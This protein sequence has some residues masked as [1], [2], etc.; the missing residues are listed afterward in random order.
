MSPFVIFAI[1][2]TI[3]HLQNPTVL[4]LLQK[5]RACGHDNK[6]PVWQEGRKQEQR[7]SV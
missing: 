5:H 2:L 1:S 4:S 7:G 3:A 6:R